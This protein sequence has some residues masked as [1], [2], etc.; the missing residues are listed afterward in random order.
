MGLVEGKLSSSQNSCYA[1][2]VFGLWHLNCLSSKLQSH[3]RHFETARQPGNIPNGFDG[4]VAR[5][6]ALALEWL[7][8]NQ[9]GRG[10]ADRPTC[11]GM[12]RRE[13]KLIGH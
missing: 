12:V 7:D 8:E 5:L 9:D 1:R 3:L 13:V 2:L 10:Q 6:V 4:V 11:H